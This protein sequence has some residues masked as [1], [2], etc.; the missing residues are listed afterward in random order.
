MLRCFSPV[1][2]KFLTG[3]Y[4]FDEDEPLPE[5]ELPLLLLPLPSPFSEE[6]DSVVLVSVVSTFL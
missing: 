6:L 5:F 2:G 4:S 1:L 3:T